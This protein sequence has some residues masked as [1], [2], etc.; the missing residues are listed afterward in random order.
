MLY[1]YL[2]SYSDFKYINEY[3][4]YIEKWSRI[5]KNNYKR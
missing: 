1:S 5:T 2:S 3:V 4:S